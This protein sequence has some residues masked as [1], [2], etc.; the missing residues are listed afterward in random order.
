MGFHKFNAKP[1]RRIKG[2]SVASSPILSIMPTLFEN[3]GRTQVPL[4]CLCLV[5]GLSSFKIAAR[6][7]WALRCL[8]L[9]ANSYSRHKPGASFVRFNTPIHGRPFIVSQNHC[10]N[11]LFI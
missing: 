8:G 3:G 9:A 4:L 2:F 11:L 10:N 7:A 6:V 1:R 5:K